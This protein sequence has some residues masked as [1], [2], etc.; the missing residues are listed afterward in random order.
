M[1]PIHVKEI[2]EK[3]VVERKI[4]IDGIY[5]MEAPK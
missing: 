2:L 1:A 4:G 5:E 3:L